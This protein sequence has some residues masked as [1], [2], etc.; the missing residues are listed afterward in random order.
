MPHSASCDFH[1]G[2]GSVFVFAGEAAPSAASLKQLMS[3][4]TQASML[5]SFFRCSL[6]SKRG[7]WVFENVDSPR[8]TAQ[9]RDNDRG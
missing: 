7:R 1:G 2:S 9:F 4:T 6:C 8:L 5:G 3:G